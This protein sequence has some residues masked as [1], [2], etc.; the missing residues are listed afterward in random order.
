MPLFER[1]PLETL[2]PAKDRWTP[3]YL[4][5]GRLE[6]DDSSVK[7]I[8]AEG[9]LCRIPVAT[10]SAL[11]LGPGTTITH[12]AVKACAES[13]TPICWTGEDSM[14]FYAFGLTPNHT[15]DM[16]R[17]HAEAWAD[18]RRRT[19]IARAMFRI[20]FPETDMEGKTIKEMRGMEG[21]RVRALYARLGI[22]YGVTWKGRN[23]NRQNWDVADNINKALSA[24]NASLYALC[25]A[26][27][28]SLGYLPSL[29]FVHDGG[30]LPFVY[31][32]A[33]LYK[34]LVSIPAAFQA[35]RQ[36][37]AGSSDLV[38]QLL[39]ERIEEETLLQRIPKDLAALFQTDEA[40]PIQAGARPP[41]AIQ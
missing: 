40:A 18:K 12:A 31:D 39:K 35:V 16:P 23:Y 21:L 19:Q 6:V 32:V 41:S 28:C 34:H 11:I 4:E 36:N 26:V 25:A 13:N 27:I 1:P 8:S 14:R 29:G 15:N 3:I 33:D 30:T 20:R 10:V 9:L 5:H 17:I 2:A 24:A 22:E 37:P 7:W 38:R